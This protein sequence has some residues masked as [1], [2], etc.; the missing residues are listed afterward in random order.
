V[1]PHD[2]LYQID[3]LLAD[4]PALSVG[5]LGFA[6]LT[7]FMILKKVKLSVVQS[8]PRE[9]TL[10]LSFLCFVSG[11][12]FLFSHL[13]SSFFLPRYST[14]HE[15]RFNTI[16]PVQRETTP[17]ASPVR[18]ALSAR[19]CPAFRLVCVSSISGL[20]FRSLRS[21][22]W[23]RTLFYAYTAGVGYTGD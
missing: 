16:I 1:V 22:S 11:P 5:L 3:K 8:N 20:L 2:L 6:T 15:Y 19:V 18:S 10:S 9:I 17:R 7:F 13:F 23:R 14:L 12:P 4:I 21:A